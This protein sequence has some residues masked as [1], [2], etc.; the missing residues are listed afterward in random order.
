MKDAPRLSAK[1]G[2]A[3]AKS[4]D[5]ILVT[6]A[7]GWIGRAT[8]ELLHNTLGTEAFDTRVVALG[9]ADRELQLRDGTRIRQRSL[10]EI[11]NLDAR[12]SIVLHLAFLTKDRA[13]RMDEAEY[14]RANRAVSET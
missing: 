12:P 13:E 6:G 9:S 10:V 4:S 7:G 8:L 1:V 14:I 11:A 3:L 2:E 5:R